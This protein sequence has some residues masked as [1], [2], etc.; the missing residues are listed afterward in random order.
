MIGAAALATLHPGRKACGVCGRIMTVH[1][2]AVGVTCDRRRCKHEQLKRSLRDH[3]LRA[4]AIRERL[5]RIRDRAARAMPDADGDSLPL[6]VLPSN[7][8]RLTRLPE[9]RRRA[10]RDYLERSID[11]ATAS[12][13]DSRSPPEPRGE[14]PTAAEMSVLGH[15]CATCRGACCEQGGDHAFLNAEQ[16]RRRMARDPHIKP[17]ELFDY[18]ISMLPERTYSGSCIFHCERGCALPREMRSS[19]CNDFC[20]E[21]LSDLWHA[22]A[23]SGS[24]RAFVGAVSGNRIVRSAMIDEQRMRPFHG[25]AR[26]AR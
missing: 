18:Y 11:E 7:D 3:H 2:Q 24:R 25:A 4:T 15:G 13:S 5:E 12:A 17:G 20:C 6:A 26:R 16:M 1:Q 21:G 10:F 23:C 8:R 9:K 19:L 22:M 14:T